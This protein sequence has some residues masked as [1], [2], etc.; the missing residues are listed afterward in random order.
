MV[1]KQTADES[2]EI[3]GSVATDNKILLETAQK[4]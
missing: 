4:D 1:E 2:V 3:G